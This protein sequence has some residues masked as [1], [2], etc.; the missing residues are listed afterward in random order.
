ME[1]Y[2][3][4]P[5]ARKQAIRAAAVGTIMSRTPVEIVAEMSWRCIETDFNGSVSTEQNEAV[6]A[7]NV[8]FMCS[9]VEG[10]EAHINGEFT[11]TPRDD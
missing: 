4:S 9:V 10:M 1:T 3:P 7:F 8:K 6:M 5:Q 11:T 2:T